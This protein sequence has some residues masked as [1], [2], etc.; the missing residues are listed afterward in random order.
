MTPTIHMALAEV[1]AWD[2]DEPLEAVGTTAGRTLRIAL[3]LSGRRTWRLTATLSMHDGVQTVTH[4]MTKDR[5]VGA[6]EA[7]SRAY[8]ATALLLATNLSET[9]RTPAA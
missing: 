7:S 6:Y 3:D 9:A 8:E 2:G 5:I 4:K 1:A